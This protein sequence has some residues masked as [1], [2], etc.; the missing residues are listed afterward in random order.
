[1]SW[2]KRRLWPNTNPRTFRWISK[3]DD[4]CYVE[5]FT[6][7]KKK[8]LRY[9]GSHTLLFSPKTGHWHISRILPT[10]QLETVAS[11]DQS[12]G[13]TVGFRRILFLKKV[14]VKGVLTNEKGALSVLRG[15]FSLESDSVLQGRQHYR[16]A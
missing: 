13:S 10:N 5:V 12:K 2:I 9:F 3:T 14:K 6:A 1:M 15:I 4:H 8:G 16:K 11:P 7:E